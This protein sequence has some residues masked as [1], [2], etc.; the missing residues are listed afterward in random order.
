MP[1]SGIVAVGTKYTVPSIH[2]IPTNTYMMDSVPIAQ[3]LES[4][5]PDPPL[6]LTSD[7]G[8]EIESKARSGSG[9][10]V[11]SSIM[12]REIRILAP[13]SQEYFRRNA[14]AAIGHR[15]EDLLDDDKE[16]RAWK[17]VAD[18]M[19]HVGELLL[20]NKTKGP[21]ILGAQP[22]ITDFFITASLQSARMIDEGVFQRMV[23]F[24]GYGEIYEACQPFMDKRD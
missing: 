17:E 14:E 2:H 10:T 12:P 13:R 9:K 7:L 20:T 15:L 24:P 22:S 6:T 4:T 5:Y 11:R 1:H 8:R 21:F 19:R 18:D 3:F 16:D 23:Q